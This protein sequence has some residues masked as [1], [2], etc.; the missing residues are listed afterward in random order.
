MSIAEKALSVSDIFCGIHEILLLIKLKKKKHKIIQA[1]L[2][3]HY[4]F[5]DVEKTFVVVEK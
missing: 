1:G 4:M 2:N 3:T 5:V